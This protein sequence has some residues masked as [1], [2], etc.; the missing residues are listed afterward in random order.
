MRQDCVNAVM[1]AAAK[2]GKVL[3]P[4]DVR[5]IEGRLRQAM[6]DEARSNVDEWKKLTPKEQVARAGERAAKDIIAE[7]G[8][9][10]ANVAR[11]IIKH[12]QNQAFIDAQ[13]AKG[14]RRVDAIQHLL[15]N[16]LD[17]K[18]GFKTLESSIEG[19]VRLAKSSMEP[20]SQ[21][22][23]KYMGFWTDRVMLHDIMRELY[24]EDTGN[25]K[26]RHVAKLWTDTAENLRKQFNEL[27]G[28]IRKLKGWAAPQDHSAFKI[29]RASV[30]EWINDTLPKLNREMYVKEDGSY[31]NDVEMRA[32]LGEI[33]NTLAT[34]GAWNM[35]STE[36]SSSIKNRGQDRRVLHFQDAASYRDYHAKYGQKSLLEMMNSHIETMGR[37]IG[38]LQTLGPNAEAGLRALLDDAMRRDTSSGMDVRDARKARDKAEI[39]FNLASGKMGSMGDPRIAHGAQVIRSWLSAARLG[40]ASLSAITDS[41]NGMMVARSWNMNPIAAW[42]KWEAKAWSSQDFRQMMRSQGVGVEAITHQISRYGEEVFGHGWSNNLANTIFRVSGLNFIDNVRR[43]AT[44]AMLFDRIAT[45]AREHETLDSA[46]PDDVARLRDAGVSEKTWEVWRQASLGHD[47]MLTPAR[48]AQLSNRSE[49][50]RRD[51]M[52]QLVGAVSRDV[53]TVV[54]MPTLKARASIEYAAL[55]KRGTVSGEI[56]RSV[57]QFKSFPLAMISNHWQRMMAQPTP[58][59]KALYAAEL[60]ATSTILGAAS[61]Q[62]KSMVAGNNPQDISDPKFAA[63]AFVQGGAAGLYGD[64]LL[65][66][67]ASPFKERLTDQMGPLSGS[68]ADL[69]DLGRAAYDSTKPDSKANLGGDVTRF[70][71]GNTPG[72]NLFWARAAFDHL[73]FQRL[74]DYYS[75]GYAERAQQRQQKYYGSGQWWPTAN[76]NQSTMQVLRSV[77]PPNLGAAVGRGQ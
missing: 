29:A 41:S 28:N 23:Q 3:S 63:R 75:P 30:D 34:D 38:A 31:M 58:T 40:S 64:V 45:L 74:Q 70:I 59:G 51:A 9:A 47:E 17:N 60:I 67:Y 7:K 68:M 37:N 22:T 46:H 32:M 18:S 5:N 73:I 56:A 62:L 24:G 66:L 53:D 15:S 6:R 43:V 72:A 69:Y 26:A 77:Q 50:V 21:A 52:Q 2:A 14:T 39:M 71:R 36:G 13:A 16:F 44:G 27:G 20:I 4:T 8:R 35:T 61:V 19:V 57:L 25:A 76:A 12:D 55:G 33:R 10:A 1:T 65:N 49:S 54:P 11:Q 42:A 48:I